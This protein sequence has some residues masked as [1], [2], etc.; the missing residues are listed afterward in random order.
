MRNQKKQRKKQLKDSPGL[1]LLL[2]PVLQVVVDH[3]IPLPKKSFRRP[4]SG[5]RTKRGWAWG[6]AAASPAWAGRAPARA[7]RA[8]PGGPSGRGRGSTRAGR[9]KPARLGTRKPRHKI[10]PRLRGQALAHGRLFADQAVHLCNQERP[11]LALNHLTPDQVH[12]PGKTPPGNP[13]GALPLF[14]STNRAGRDS[15]VTSM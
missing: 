15:Q 11:H 5:W 2:R 13:N 7:A 12:L 6:A 8:R 3:G 9:T 1:N 4:F 10:A 14:L